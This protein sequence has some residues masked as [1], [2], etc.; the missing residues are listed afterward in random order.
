MSSIY[1]Y[2]NNLNNNYLQLLSIWFWI[3]RIASH[4]SNTKLNVNRSKCNYCTHG[5]FVK[6]TTRNLFIPIVA[7]C[8][9]VAFFFCFFLVR[10]AKYTWFGMQKKNYRSKI[11]ETII[12]N[13]HREYRGISC[14]CAKV[15]LHNR[16]RYK[17]VCIYVSG[18]LAMVRHLSDVKYLRC[19]ST[20]T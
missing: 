7:F 11:P 17:C 4:S 8:T 3:D 9:F 2:T 19:S 6:L 20:H 15:Y 10:F 1:I 16:V 13:H 14:G 5:S 18:T 12:I